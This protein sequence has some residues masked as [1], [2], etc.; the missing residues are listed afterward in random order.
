MRSQIIIISLYS[1]ILFNRPL[2]PGA[3]SGAAGAAGAAEP[4]SFVSSL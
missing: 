3:N 2:K 1:T 4:A